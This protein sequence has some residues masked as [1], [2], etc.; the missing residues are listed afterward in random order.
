MDDHEA[1]WDE[2][3]DAMPAGWWVGTP[4]YHD[5]RR[6]WVLYAYD[7]SERPVVG[8][9]QREWQAVADSE[10]GVVR[11]MARCLREIAAGRVPK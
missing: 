2:L 3:R 4:S 1:A 10:L 7:P 11:E 8:L 5:E 6:E 9:R